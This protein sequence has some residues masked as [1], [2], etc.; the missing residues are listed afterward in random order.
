MGV[1][2]NLTRNRPDFVFNIAEG[3]GVTRGRESQVPAVLE[4]LN[5]PYSGSDPVALA[6]TLDKWLTH[7]IL[8]AGNVAVPSL[9]MFSTE[10]DLR[11]GNRIFQEHGEYIVK[12]RWEGSSKGVFPDSV[13]SDCKNLAHKVR[14]IWRRYRQP[15]LVE[16]FLPGE[17]IT[18]G[19]V[20]NRVPRV[21]GM[22][23]IDPVAVNGRKLYSIEHKRNWE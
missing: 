1:C 21:I 20:G 22:M 23:A 10:E 18:V 17:E 4:S 2:D 5:I 11:H 6:V 7:H 13:V 15:A 14:R 9:Y 19:L 8:S 12:P 3:S 16:E